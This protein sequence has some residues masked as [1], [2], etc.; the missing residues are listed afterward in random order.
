MKLNQLVVALSACALLA[1]GV[2]LGGAASTRRPSSQ[3]K[4]WVPIHLG[5]LDLSINKAV[6]Y[7]LVG[8]ALTCLLGIGLMRWRAQRTCPAAARRFGE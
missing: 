1:P 2:G 6:V 8:A 5:G 3:L 4:D 7:L